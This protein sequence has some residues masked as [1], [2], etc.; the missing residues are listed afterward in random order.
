VRRGCL[1]GYRL[2][3]ASRNMPV[4]APALLLLAARANATRPGALLCA[5]LIG[6]RALRLRA[7]PRIGLYLI[8]APRTSTSRWRRIKGARSMRS[9]AP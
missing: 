3:A 6:Y 2:D 1:H 7:T 8:R 5:G 9:R 4:A